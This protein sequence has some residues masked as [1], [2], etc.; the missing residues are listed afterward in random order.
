MTDS[1]GYFSVPGLSPFRKYAINAVLPSGYAIKELQSFGSPDSSKPVEVSV[2]S[3]AAVKSMQA[4]PFRNTQND[5]E[6]DVLLTAARNSASVQD[7]I[8]CIRRGD[9]ADIGDLEVTNEVIDRFLTHY[10]PVDM[11]NTYTYETTTYS[12]VWEPE[13]THEMVLEGTG[14][15]DIID[16][17]G[18]IVRAYEWIQ[19]HG[20]P[21]STWMRIHDGV[22]YWY[23]EVE[24]QPGKAELG[25]V[26]SLRD[27]DLTTLEL[28]DITTKA[29]TFHTLKV[30]ARSPLFAESGTWWLAPGVGMVMYRGEQDIE[31]G[32]VHR[33]G[34]ELVD[35]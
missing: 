20:A 14:K 27:K 25:I 3:T 32:V 13:E 31:P 8:D 5:A 17:D 7:L 2:V 24:G 10:Y 29:G 11:R 18:E 26:Y 15:E 33:Y 23:D 28:E 35:Y 21:R 12:D 9:V 16:V 1:E 22:L 19:G 30:T 4:L 34:L 6:F